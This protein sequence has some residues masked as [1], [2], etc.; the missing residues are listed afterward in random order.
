MISRFWLSSGGIIRG[1]SEVVLQVSLNK[2]I[3]CK[4]FFAA[5]FSFVHEKYRYLIV[6]SESP[7]LL[8]VWCGTV[9]Q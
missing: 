5:L 9:L 7:T 8:S 4:D 2:K 6:S 1:S 3:I